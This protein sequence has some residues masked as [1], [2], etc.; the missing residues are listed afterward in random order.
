MNSRKVY[1]FILLLGLPLT[2]LAQAEAAFNGVQL[3]QSVEEVRQKL[4][5]ISENIETFR[6]E[7]PVFPLARKH[8][9]HLVCHSVKLATG[10]IESVVFT[11]ADDKLSYIEARGNAYGTCMYGLCVL[12]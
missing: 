3:Q 2:I 4:I 5:P 9:S 12:F 7:T 10:Q 11:F 1:A 6:V 8:E